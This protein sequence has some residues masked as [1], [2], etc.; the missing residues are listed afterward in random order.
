MKKYSVGKT[1]NAIE[2]GEERTFTV[3]EIRQIVVHIVKWD[4]DEQAHHIYPAV[5]ERV[6]KAWQ[7][8]H[9]LEADK[10]APPN[11]FI[12]G[13]RYNA[14][15]NGE[16]C[17]FTLLD[18]RDELQYFLR[19][20]ETDQEFVTNNGLM[21]IWTQS[22]KAKYRKE[23]ANLKTTFNKGQFFTGPGFMQETRHSSPRCTAVIVN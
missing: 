2:K 20:N 15:K 6:T 14:I 21:D 17:I 22:W 7:V 11:E 4:A 9:G 3:L 10:N 12:I 13:K 1:Y 16:Q 18:K 19:W 23:N 5:L 8:S